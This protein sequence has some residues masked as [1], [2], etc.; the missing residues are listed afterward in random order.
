VVIDLSKIDLKENGFA[1]PTGSPKIA[2]AKSPKPP[3][4]KIT[5][6]LPRSEWPAFITTI[7]TYLKGDDK[8]VGD[9]VRRAA[10]AL[11]HKI[12][13]AGLRACGIK[14]S[15]DE[16]LDSVVNYLNARFPYSPS[17]PTGS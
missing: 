1:N 13:V 9:S 11:G 16:R 15:C 6:P 14:C 10:D 3:T 5:I 17:Q 7:A 4:A 12:V 2:N 8:G